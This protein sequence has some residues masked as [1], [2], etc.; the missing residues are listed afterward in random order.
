MA[1]PARLGLVVIGGEGAIVLGGVAAATAAQPLSGAP[2]FLAIPLM[3]LAAA[4]AGAAWIGAVGALRAYRGV[5]E[6]IASLLMSYIAI[7]LSNHLIEGVLRDP[8]SLNKPPP[9]R[10][11]T[12]SWSARCPAWRSIGGSVSAFSPACSPTS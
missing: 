11:E 9:G 7:A 12:P 10:S 3:G 2:P 8:Q 5:N 1:L 6:T 4:A